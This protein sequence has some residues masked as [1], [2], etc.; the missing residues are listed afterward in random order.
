VESKSQRKI[1]LV[2]KESL[3]IIEDPLIKG[4]S[5]FNPISF[6][7]SNPESKKTK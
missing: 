7:I 2:K 1:K 4:L 3:N 6:E 5:K